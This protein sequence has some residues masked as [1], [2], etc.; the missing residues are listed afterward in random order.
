[1][2]GAASGRGRRRRRYIPTPTSDRATEAA[3]YRRVEGAR[4]PPGAPDKHEN[5]I[6]DEGARALA[7][8]AALPKDLAPDISYNNIADKAAA[9]ALTKAIP[10]AELYRDPKPSDG[11]SSTARLSGSTGA[12]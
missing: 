12:T 9:A 5:E 10:G 8:S 4:R 11:R 6:G 3:G 7:S 1:L 2:Y